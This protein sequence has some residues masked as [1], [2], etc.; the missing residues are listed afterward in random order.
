[1]SWRGRI[2]S[3]RREREEDPKTLEPCDIEVLIREG[4]AEM[5][6]CI[7]S[8]EIEAYER[9][10]LEAERKQEAELKK[11]KEEQWA[12]LE[13]VKREDPE[14]ISEPQSDVV[15]E[16]EPESKSESNDVETKEAEGEEQNKQDTTS[17]FGCGY[18]RRKR[19]EEETRR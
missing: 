5:R 12:G 2:T 14:Q 7:H 6:R 13:K 18:R 19:D 3:G 10:E 8:R 16:G 15:Q 9:E 1:M 17:E 11:K 4:E